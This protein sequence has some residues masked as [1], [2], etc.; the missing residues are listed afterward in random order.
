MGVIHPDA[1]LHKTRPNKVIINRPPLLVR[2]FGS[3]AGVSVH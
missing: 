3:V 1:Q 2:L